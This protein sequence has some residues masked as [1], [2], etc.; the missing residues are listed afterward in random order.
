MIVLLHP[1]VFL[2]L[3]SAGVGLVVA[4]VAGRRD[5]PAARTYAVLMTV[6]AVWSLLYVLQLLQPT[7]AAKQ[8]WL[9]IRNSLSPLVSVLFWLFAARYTDRRKL[10]SMRY[11]GPVLAAGA[12]IS[13]A[14]VLNFSGL[15]VADFTLYTE[16]GFDRGQMSVG[17]L[18]WIMIAYVFVVV[19]GGHVY[20]V[21]DM[22]S[23]FA[24][25]RRQLAAMAVVG[26]GE[27]VLLLLF[28][29]D[30]IGVLP[31]L[32]PWPHLQLI[33]YSM[34]VVALPLG[35]SYFRESLFVLQPLDRQL[36]IENMDDAVFVFDENS[37]LRNTNEHARWLVGLDE[38]GSYEG[39][40]VRE[41]FSEFPALLEI[42]RA[43]STAAQPPGEPQ[44]QSDGTLET[45]N[46]AE[47]SD[48]ADTSV[49][50][51]AG[52]E[53]DAS[54]QLSAGDETRHYDFRVSSIRSS[55]DKPLGVVVVARD[56]TV[57]RRQRVTLS[58]RTVELEEKRAE[59]ERQNER[60]EK[61]ASMVS[62][63]LRNPLN[64]AQIRAGMIDQEQGDENLDAVENSL[65]R[66][67]TMIDEMLTMARAGQTIE[68]P[69]ECVL[70]DIA[71]QAWANVQAE[72]TQLDTHLEGATI[73][74][75][76]NRLMQVFENLF[77]NTVDHNEPPLTI[78]VG[79]L[80]DTEGFYVE[81]T[82]S[83]IPEHERENIFEHG[84][85][86]S[87]GGSGYGLAIVSDVIEAHG[88][89]IS[90]TDS[91]DGGTRMEIVT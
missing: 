8:P 73:E 65:E 42:Y 28:V 89:R 71:V 36:V 87:E 69:E 43:Q 13:L 40:P 25:Y 12:V 67:E 41:V 86:T 91:Q 62:H 6:L 17:P 85:T 39:K 81:D 52:D 44:E 45:T 30:H 29:T 53:A 19:G 72:G 75:D 32:N 10:L 82:G 66:M 55:N 83:G 90:V 34:V 26:I 64:V 7:A 54:V 35:W 61:F 49:Q 79:I 14:T 68:E 15:F 51:S 2:G 78:R 88:W 63:D 47:P 22:V 80:D 60:L 84:Y 33:T 23:S 11:L 5:S 74:A 9:Q 18:F 37:H 56:V 77:R 1:F 16:G 31:A 70:S 46:R 48:E 4:A 59:L 21:L 3:V 76:H 38:D 58:E 57:R 20:I 50:L 24:V 27:F